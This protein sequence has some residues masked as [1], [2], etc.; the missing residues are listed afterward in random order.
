MKNWFLLF[1]FFTL[2]HSLHAQDFKAQKVKG[3]PTDEVYALLADSKGFIWVAH[4]LGISRYDGVSFTNFHHPKEMGLGITDLLEDQ[5]GRI[6]LHNFNGQ[7]F[8]IE[9]EEMHLLKEYRFEQESSFPRMAVLGNELVA[10][11]DKGLFICNTQNLQCKYLYYD[12]SNLQTRSLATVNNI[13]YQYDGLRWIS[14]SQ[15][16]GMQELPFRNRTS[17]NIDSINPILQPLI[18]SDT[19]Y[20]KFNKGN[21]LKYVIRNNVVELVEISG[22]TNFVNTITKS[23]NDIWINTKTESHTVDNRINIANYNLTD[24]EIDREGNT[25]YSSLSKGLWFLQKTK[26]WEENTATGL[27]ENDFIT[28]FTENN[29]KY[30]YGTQNGNI[31]MKDAG[32]NKT[33]WQYKLPAILG[34]VENFFRIS[35]HE[36][37]I[38][39]SLGHYYLNTTNNKIYQLSD[40]VTMKS[41]AFAGDT[42]F[43]AYARSLEIIPDFKKIMGKTWVNEKQF[44]DSLKTA[45]SHEIPI[46][47]KR[48]YNVCFDSSSQEIFAGFSDGLFRINNKIFEPILF[49][50]AKISASSLLSSRDK[51]F[52][53][54]I[55]NG[56]YIISKGQIKNIN[57]TNGLLSNNIL[58]LKRIGDQLFIIE[59]ENIQVIEVQTGTVDKAMSLPA[60]RS[61]LVYDLWKEDGLINIATN[62]NL[63]KTSL[64]SFNSSI[65]PV[66]YLLSVKANDSSIATQQYVTLPYFKNNIQFSIAS[67]SAIYPAITYF[68]YRLLNNNDTSWLQISASQ[69]TISFT[70]LP[71]GHYVFEAYAVNFQNNYAKPIRFAFQ[72][73]NPWWKEAWFYILI[74]IVLISI[75][76][77]LIQ[78][79]IQNIKKHQQELIERLHLK[80]DL[81]KSLLSTIKAQM[82]PHFIFNSLNA[83]QSFVY[84]DDKKSA[85]IY[86]G[87]FSDLVRNILDNSNKN[88]ISLSH[89]IELLHL[90]LDLEKVRFEKDLNIQFDIAADIDFD[91]ISLPPMLVQPYV[92]NAIA[93]GLFHKKGSRDLRITIKPTPE[94]DYVEICID[95]NGIGRKLSLEINAKRKDHISFSNSANEKRI[96]LINQTLVRKIKI[97]IIDKKDEEQNATGTTVKLFIPMND[98][99]EQ[100]QS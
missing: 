100:Y 7:I 96:E 81:R 89:D 75:L 90:Y 36:L 79:R 12:T 60:N 65:I 35:D 8:Y 88:E 41:I 72:I 18:T 55:N 84:T 92:E 87:K 47:S 40:D 52:V 49:N 85:S 95:D 38:G 16:N 3:L 29:H 99:K 24:I 58:E 46:R 78:W 76:F 43:A 30:I 45:I 57:I 28:H 93:H 17:K 31:I 86:L 23:K 6:W 71:P 66:N 26:F 13:V 69:R 73:L 34:S 70:S 4:S 67:P 42:L 10:S 56:I 54:S 9:K 77:F 48:C 97:E 21:L 11:S 2:G 80:N 39:L 51:L 59:P 61:G 68:K 44:I 25:W 15:Q 19:I 22:E 94:K 98:L 82:N 62:K 91:Q 32:T 53:G 14:Y 74:S 5:Q 37:L 1:L 33:E 27:D 83:I 63:F 20:A 50:N 64:K